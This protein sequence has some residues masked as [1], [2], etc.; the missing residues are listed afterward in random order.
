MASLCLGIDCTPTAEEEQLFLAI[1]TSFEIIM[2]IMI[3]CKLESFFGALFQNA[4]NVA[5]FEISVMQLGFAFIEAGSVRAKNTTNILVKNVID[6]GSSSKRKSKKK[7][8]KKTLHSLLS[9]CL[10]LLLNSVGNISL[11]VNRLRIC[12]WFNEQWNDRNQ[13]ILFNQHRFLRIQRLFL[14]ICFR[15]NLSHNR[16]WSH[17]RTSNTAFLF[18]FHHVHDRS[19]LS[20]RY[21]LGMEHERVVI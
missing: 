19:Y 8:Q 13:Q 3:F 21:P 10:T 16:Q 15:G 4:S 18:N 6:A 12:I 7:K 5:F 9:F 20:H 11:L 17:R 2:A 1:N 14:S